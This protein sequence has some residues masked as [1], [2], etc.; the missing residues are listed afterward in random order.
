MLGFKE[1]AMDGFK[2]DFEEFLA[3]R[4]FCGDLTFKHAEKKVDIMVCPPVLL[5]HLAMS[6]GI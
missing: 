1:I 5:S 6:S 3:R 2:K 4:D